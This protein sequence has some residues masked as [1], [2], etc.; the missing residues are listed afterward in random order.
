MKIKMMIAAVM[1]SG[2]AMSQNVKQTSDGNY[3]PAPK[4]TIL[5]ME[6]EPTGEIHVQVL[7]GTDT[8]AYDNLNKAQ[9][10]DLFPGM[11]VTG[12]HFKEVDGR[13]LPVLETAK[14]KLFVFRQ[15][16]NGKPYRFY[17]KE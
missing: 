10:E 12:K 6:Q 3:I 4:V 8:V 5:K 16:K 15:S 1:L 9:F 2:M 13:L 17:F 14:G 7:E 11:K